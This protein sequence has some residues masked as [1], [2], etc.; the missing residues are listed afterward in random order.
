MKISTTPV[1]TEFT[2]T[3]SVTAD[4]TEG[5]TDAMTEPVGV[6]PGLELKPGEV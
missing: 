1:N 5:K 3:N 4:S 2:T 6:A